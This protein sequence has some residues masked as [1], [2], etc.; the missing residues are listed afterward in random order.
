ML[1]NA[2]DYDYLHD[3]QYGGRKGHSAIDIPM[4]T[5]FI[6]DVLHSMGANTIFTDCSA[7][8]CYN[9]I[10]AT[11]TSFVEYKAGLPD[12]ACILLAKALEQMKYTM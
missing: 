10:D 4:L 7:K 11:I 8:A 12:N 9:R 3:S 5:A 6:L 1:R 2:E